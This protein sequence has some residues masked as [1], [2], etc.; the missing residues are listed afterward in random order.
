MTNCMNNADYLAKSIDALGVFDLLSA[1]LREG[2][3]TLPLVV[4]RIKPDVRIRELLG[5]DETDLVR[6]LRTRGWIMIIPAYN[7]PT[8]LQELVLQA[9]RLPL[10]A[11]L[12]H[13]LHACTDDDLRTMQYQLGNASLLGVLRQ[14]QADARSSSRWHEEEE[15]G[16]QRRGVSADATT[17]IAS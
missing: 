14:A 3:P 1:N 15:E 5:F 13:L 7:L 4:F 12:T 16:G 10:G 6:E 17:A 9:A 11:S 8:P 2:A